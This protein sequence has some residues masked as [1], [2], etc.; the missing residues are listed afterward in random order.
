[1]LYTPP[2][3]SVKLSLFLKRVQFQLDNGRG[4]KYLQENPFLAGQ[5]I[6]QIAPCYSVYLMCCKE[7]ESHVRY[8]KIGMSK[9]IN[10]RLSAIN[11]DNALKVS[12]VYYFCV[13]DVEMT[14]R[15]ESHMHARFDEYRYHNEWFRFDEGTK[16][17]YGQLHQM[18]EEMKLL[19]GDDYN[20]FVYDPHIAYTD[21][22]LVKLRKYYQ[23]ALDLIDA[24]F[25]L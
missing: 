8:V 13:G 23:K 18:I 21:P 15:H 16:E 7:T 9:D 17:Y 19:L 14:L 1:M 22:R 6:H 20:T 3:Q 10:K 4:P 2:Y 12:A 24:K 25:E 11:T 5:V